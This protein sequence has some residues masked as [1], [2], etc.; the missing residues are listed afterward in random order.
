MRYGILGDIHGNL[1][2]LETVVSGLQKEG[3][4]H[5]IS[6]GDIVGYGAN[7]R[8]CIQI[9]QDLN[10][11]V[12]AGNHDW[13]AI[14][15]L[16]ATFFNVYAKQA[17]DWTSSVLSKADTD[18]LKALPLIQ[19]VDNEITV[20]HATIADPDQ[21]NYIQTYYDAARSINEMKTHVAVLGH[22]H[23]PLAF[24]MNESLRLSVS[25]KID[26][27]KTKKALINVGSIGQP[28]DENAKAAYGLYD[29]ETQTY[30]LKRARYDIRTTCKKIIDAG[31]PQI[32]AER[33]KYGR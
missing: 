19:V 25:T 21:F 31:L 15:K 30:R 18:W 22:S 17:V 28:R 1:E 24:L 8:E 10:A 12:V 6:V 7:P 27:S 23:V 4:D 11:T 16:D 14:G 26:L 2:A 29:S 13:A 9:V 20:G 33:L 3:V 5:F 32:L